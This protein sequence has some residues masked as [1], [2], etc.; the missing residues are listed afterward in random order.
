MFNKTEK[1]PICYH[2]PSS[3]TYLNF[4]AKKKDKAYFSLYIAI[5]T[6]MVKY[7]SMI[8]IKLVDLQV[9]FCDKGHETQNYGNLC[10]GL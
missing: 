1:T 2:F 7:I 10:L 4:G 8:N 9:Q 5:C 6:G 3:K